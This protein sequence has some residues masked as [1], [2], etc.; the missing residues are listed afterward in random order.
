MDLD[1]AG[2]TALVTASSGGIG[3]EIARSLAA[4]GARVTI[5]GRSE[6][7]VGKAIEDV[8]KT[9]PAADLVPLVADNGTA[10]GCA[11]TIAAIPAADILVNNLGIYEAVGF[12]DE[13]DE[14]WQRL[15]EVNVMS[16]VRLARHYLKG[17]IDRGKGR[18]VFISSESGISPA[19]EMAHYSATK[20]IQ[21]GISRSLAELTKGTRVTVNSV[22]PGPT[23]TEGVEKFISGVYPGLDFAEAERRFMAENR[24]SSL[25]ARL[26]DPKEIGDVVSFVC[27]ERASAINGSNIRAEGGLIRSAF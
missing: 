18:V 2:K 13:T 17:M 22:L 1:L 6:A 19:P 4:E 5:N 14:A 27:S 23:R 25:I 24:P 7:A 8:R 16:G 3:L 11:V 15:F 10:E 12:F 21:L 20:T 9:H 26:I